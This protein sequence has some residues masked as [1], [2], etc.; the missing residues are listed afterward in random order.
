MEMSTA[1]LATR[2]SAF[3]SSC[4]SECG[5][6]KTKFG[7]IKGY[8]NSRREAYKELELAIGSVKTDMI[9]FGDEILTKVSPLL[10]IKSTV[11]N[12]VG[13][14]RKIISELNCTFL[15]NDINNLVD[16]MCVAYVPALFNIVKLIAAGSIC[17]LLSTLAAYTSAMKTSKADKK[18]D[19]VTPA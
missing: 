4:A 9:A 15:F 5:S 2:Y 11:N 7:Y 8:D 1:S 3:C 18:N 17:F 16:A 6:A 12:F 13:V 10:T 14:V 19:N